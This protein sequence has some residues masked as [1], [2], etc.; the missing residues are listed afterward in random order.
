[1]SRAAGDA[2]RRRARS[3]LRL[4]GWLM[5]LAGAL[6]FVVWRQSRGVALQAE[7]RALEAE[8]TIAE[9]ERL[10]LVRKIQALSSRARIVRV[11]RERLGMHVPTDR[12]IMLLTDPTPAVDS[13][14]GA[15]L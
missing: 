2:R 6:G 3:A 4:L 5:L 9:S 7:L 15:G 11:A 10:E 14:A 8:R 1:V 13:A 12:E